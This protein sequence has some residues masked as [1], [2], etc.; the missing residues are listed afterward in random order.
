MVLPRPQR[1]LAN[2]KLYL[3][4]LQMCSSHMDFTLWLILILCSPNTSFLPNATQ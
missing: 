3:E 2:L 1:N 4:K